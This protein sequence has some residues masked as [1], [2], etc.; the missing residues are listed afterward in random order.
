M[1]EIA[2]GMVGVTLGACGFGGRL[3]ASVRAEVDALLSST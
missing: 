2:G 1:Q 3:G